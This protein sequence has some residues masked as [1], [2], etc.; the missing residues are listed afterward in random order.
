MGAGWTVSKCCS[1]RTEAIS[2]L[3]QKREVN[4]GAPTLPVSSW[5][6]PAYP[7]IIRDAWIYRAQ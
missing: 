6:T 1:L 5:L 3:S 2:S 4:L 7:S